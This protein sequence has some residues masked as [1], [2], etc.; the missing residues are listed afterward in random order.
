MRIKN[1]TKIVSPPVK[2]LEAGPAGGRAKVEAALKTKLPDSYIEYAQTYGSGL[3]QNGNV[4]V[5]NIYNPLAKKYA[6]FIKDQLKTAR[7]YREEEGVEEFEYKV[8][9]KKPGV[10]PLGSNDAFALYYLV[11]GDDPENWPIVAKAHD[12]QTFSRYDLSLPDFLARLF[13]AE[14]PTPPWPNKWYKKGKGI[15]FEPGELKFEEPRQYRTLLQLYEDNGNK[16]DFWATSDVLRHY[17]HVFR[18][19]TIGG[20]ANGAL[21]PR[22][23]ELPIVTDYYEDGILAE[24]DYII[25]TREAKLVVY[26]TIPQ[27]DWYQPNK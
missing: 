21:R 18:V 25:P 15:L 4:D 8:Y 20:K 10:L 2:P 5:L 7:E 27:P 6:K 11:E 24:E 17:K 1:L 19:K 3:F 22:P 16:A 13:K 14:E 26:F 9:P 23:E 12:D